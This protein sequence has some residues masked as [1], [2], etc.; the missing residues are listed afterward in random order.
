MFK[1][2]T[3]TRTAV[4]EKVAKKRSAAEAALPEVRVAED[5]GLLEQFTCPI[6]CKLPVDPVHAAD[7]RVYDREY[8]MDWFGR[9]LS[10]IHI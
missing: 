7:G 2:P 8:I 3:T 4:K 1:V 5:Q 6:S 10:L 9:N